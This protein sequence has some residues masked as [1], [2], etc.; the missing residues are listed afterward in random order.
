MTT[1]AHGA[2]STSSA[3]DTGDQGYAKGLKTRHVRM[4]AIGGSIGTGLFLG[5]GGRLASGGPALA[6]VYGVCGI[7]TFFMMRALGEM[8]VYRPSSGA[9][10]SYARE[11]VGEG[12]AYITGWMFFLDW[13]TSVMAETTAIALYFHYWEPFK[14]VPQWLIALIA[15][16]VIFF[17]NL[18]N[19]KYFGEAEFWFAMIK[20]AAIVG[21]MVIAAVFI[22]FGL[23]VSGQPA[24][25]SVITDNGGLFPKGWAPMVTLALGVVFAFGGTEMVGVAAGEADNARAIIPK[26]VNSTFWRILLFYVGSVILFTMVLPWTSYSRSE[27]PFVTFFSALGIGGI[28]SIM[29][30]VVITA[31]LSSLNS[32]LYATGRTLR[33]MAVAGG[34]PKLAAKLNKNHV[35]AGGI[36]IT[37]G[38]ALIGVLINYVWPSEA[39]DIVMNLAGIGIAGTW[40][41]IMVSH[42]AFVRKARRGEVERPKFRLWAAP[43]TNIVTIVF[44][45]FVIGGMWFADRIGPPTILMFGGVCVILA[46]GWFTVVRKRINP[47]VL[48]EA[49]DA[50]AVDAEAGDAGPSDQDPDPGPST[51]GTL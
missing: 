38:L 44:L 26:A 39:F 32:G 1:D 36:A 50:D 31:A 13:C 6:F 8:A 12:G 11:F 51:K 10:V 41:S 5:A 16:A 15:L 20:V 2:Q 29:N 23:H 37:A 28:G 3:V 40:I 47:T 19:V 30:L 24:G 27:S 35:P 21:F 25:P 34:A 18:L 45:V 46:I 14:V 17:L 49:F 43:V 9:F 22:V 33:S 48:D 42:W 4:I 7:F